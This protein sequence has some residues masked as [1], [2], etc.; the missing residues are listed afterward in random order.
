[1]V[2]T[3]EKIREF[4]WEERE[5]KELQELPKSFYAELSEYLKRKGD[6]QAKNVAEDLINRRLKKMMDFALVYLKTKIYP[7]NL[8]EEEKVLFEEIVRSLRR[9][10]EIILNREVVVEEKKDE[11]KADREGKPKDGM[12][13][14][15]KSLPPFVGPDLKIYKLKKDDKVYLPEEL[16]ELLIKK[17]VVEEI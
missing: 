4:Y 13:I 6:E 7:M 14:V 3:F 16:K 9:F 12:V 8:T 11:E 15:K 17:G 1:M 5:K 2:L 10:N